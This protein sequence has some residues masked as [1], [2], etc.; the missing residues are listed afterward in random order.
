MLQSIYSNLDIMIGTRM[1]ANI[2]ALTRGTPGLP[3]G[4]LHKTLGI[5][6]YVGIEDWVLD[7]QNINGEVLA[8]KL[9][10]LFEERAQMRAPSS[11]FCR[12]L[13][14]RQNSLLN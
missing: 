10:E 4:Y 8:H 1:H 2:L 9:L 12:Q 13:L 14:I 7:I 5:A 11:M 3:I 6:R